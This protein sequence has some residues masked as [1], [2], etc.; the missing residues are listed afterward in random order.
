[1]GLEKTKEDKFRLVE[2][3]EN[4]LPEFSN[5]KQFV[6]YFSR[7][8]ITWESEGEFLEIT[9]KPILPRAHV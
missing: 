1:M 4:F 2:K 3:D 7:E 5:L 6:N 9:L 8:A